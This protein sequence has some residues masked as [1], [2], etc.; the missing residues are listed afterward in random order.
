MQVLREL[1]LLGIVSFVAVVL[2]NMTPV[3]PYIE[4]GGAWIYLSF[5]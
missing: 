3:K 1:A 4:T 2:Q 5:E